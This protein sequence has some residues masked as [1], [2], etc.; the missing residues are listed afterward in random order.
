MKCWN[1]RTDPVFLLYRFWTR[2][3]ALVKATGRG[4]ALG[5][6]LC[7]VNPEN[8]AELLRVPAD[9]G[10]ASTWRVLDIAL[11]Q[12]VCGALVTDKDGFEV[13]LIHF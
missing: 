5:L 8:Q 10:S 3:E 12:D 11:G 7:V 13:R 4:I 9:C 2:K 1:V 6:N